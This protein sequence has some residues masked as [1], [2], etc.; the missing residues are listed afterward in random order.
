MWGAIAPEYV[1]TQHINHDLRNIEV[2]LEKNGEILEKTIVLTPE[3]L[4]QSIREQV[5]I[6]AQAHDEI[7]LKAQDEL[8]MKDVDIQ[9]GEARAHFNVFKDETEY[10]QNFIHELEMLCL[11]VKASQCNPMPHLYFISSK[12]TQ[13]K[14]FFFNPLLV[15]PQWI[16]G[17]GG[18]P[19]PTIH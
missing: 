8:N 2:Q 4:L 19:S 14:W 5:K 13:T 12:N 15:I 11:G 6:F 18:G 10:A 9:L 16:V 3:K 1:I 17:A 7:S